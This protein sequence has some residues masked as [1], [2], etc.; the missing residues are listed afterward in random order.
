MRLSRILGLAALLGILPLVGCAG[1]TYRDQA[2]TSQTRYANVENFGDKVIT[3]EEIDGLL[4]EVADILKVTLEP[5]EP[6]VRIM[7]TSPSRI[8]DL[9]RHVTVVAAHGADAVGLYFPGASLVLIPSYD[10]TILGHELAH[11]LTDHYIKSTPRKDWEKIAYM[12]ED[13][14]PLKAPVAKAPAAETVVAARVAPA[15]Q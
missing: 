13:R 9:Y 6:R 7:V 10:R 5:G 14:L 15:A 12:V 3:A 11:Y 1:V 4:E 8:A 2:T